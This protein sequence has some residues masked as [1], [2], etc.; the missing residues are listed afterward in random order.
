MKA[1]SRKLLRDLKTLRIQI[2][3]MAILVACGVTVLVAS[4]SAYTSL[5]E[6]QHSYYEQYQFADLFADV[7]R[8]PQSLIKSIRNIDGV[9]IAEGRLVEDALLDIPG[10]KEPALGRFISYSPNSLINKIYLRQGRWPEKSSTIEVLVHES[11][12][13]AHHLNPGNSFFVSLKGQK[14]RLQVS[15][16]GLSPEYVYALSP[17]ALFPDDL[18]FG[19]LWMLHE[20]L[21]RLSDMQGAFNSLVVKVTPGASLERSQKSLDILLAP[22][23]S[24]GSYDR[25]RQISHLFVQDEIRQ[26]KSMSSVV[27]G[28]FIVVAAFILHTVMSRLIGLQ[29]TQIA[30]LKSLGYS[31]RE[32]IIYYWKLVTIILLLG[33]LPSILFAQGIG[34]WYAVL[35]ERY[36]RFPQISFSLSRQAILLGIVAGLVPGWLA[37]SF[38]LLEVFALNPA[39]AMRPPTPSRFHRS[40]LEKEGLIASRKTQVK[41]I[42][43]NILSRPWRSFLSILGICASTAILVNGSFWSDII[44]F[45]IQRQFQESQREDLEINFNHPRKLDVLSEIERIPGIFMVEGVR[46]I[47]VRLHFKNFKKDS[48]IASP[49]GVSTLRRILNRQGEP[50]KFKDGQVLLSAY[51]QKKFGLQEG[52]TVTF[53]LADKSHPDFS[54]VVGGF[55]DDIVGSSIY[56]TRTDLHHWISET[57][58][59]SSVYARMDPGMAEQIYIRLKQFPEVASVTVKRLLFESFNAT[60]S[61]MILT[62]TMILVAFAITISGA[63]LFNMSRI[64]LSEKAWELASM[65]I[66]GF[67]TPEV[68]RILYLEM[69]IQVCLAL[70]P[71]LFLGYGLSYLSTKWIHT[72]TFNFPL[73]IDIK[74]YALAVTVIVLT[75]FL[76][77]WFLLTKVRSLSMT[78]ALKARE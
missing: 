32:L 57:P 61:G 40:F 21:E 10:Q 65:R 20:D 73:V 77:G 11:F 29:R 17:V 52:D 51:F 7:V 47:P 8:A 60:L 24:V 14:R 12:A 22:Y 55:V 31:S 41:I 18:H 4:W 27:P 30:A 3:T 46:S 13:K 1:L 62:F 15:G 67:K 6:T 78:E 39:E 50:I 58:S 19:V 9:D 42:L 16:I 53:E 75:Y 74:T 48:V 43:R 2:I 63:V 36:F 68:F 72:D 54:A 59:I 35:Y 5:R 66:M 37:S 56:A 64:N 44:D 69:G 38:S 76:T 33:I 70:P 49:D 28:I 25:S 23:G 26:Q 34:E 45:V 71:G